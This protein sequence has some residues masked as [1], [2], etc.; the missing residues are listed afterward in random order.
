MAQPARKMHRTYK[1]LPIVVVENHHEVI[2]FIYKA[3]GAKYLPLQGSV[4]IHLD[5]HPDMLIPN[6]MKAETVFEKYA[7][8]EHLSIENW[9]MPA[10]YAGH[11]NKICW[12][13]PPWCNQIREGTHSFHIGEERNSK[14]IRVTCGEP[15]FVSDALYAPIEDLANAKPVDLEV[16]TLGKVIEE[17]GSDDFNELG[18]VVRNCISDQ[19]YILDIDLDFFST[20]NPFL[21]LYEDAEVY[22][23]LKKLYRFPNNETN[24]I[25][26]RTA[27]RKDQIEILSKF[28]THLAKYNSM[29]NLS[30]ELCSSDYMFGVQSL[31]DEIQKYYPQTKIDW[32]T[33]HDA[34]CTCD[35]SGL[36]EHVTSREDITKMI[37]VSLAGLLASLPHPPIMITISR[38]SYDN[39]CPPEDVDF[40]QNSV[41]KLLNE[42][43]SPV[44][45]TL[46]YEDKYPDQT[47]NYD[48]PGPPPVY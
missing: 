21:S 24:D 1:E 46:D 12:V 35:E 13:R 17:N 5:S 11:F 39:Y 38:S 2:P 16:V 30:T 33:I 27:K 44:K 25:N 41:L 9:I 32:E 29:G 40:I 4:M 37:D 48:V 15:Y 31:F 18:R 14:C 19:T 42:K 20:R 6:D 10:A 7:L 43:Y 47:P 36:P 3:I 28:F 8:F 26:T 23:R 34:G 22:E 45:I